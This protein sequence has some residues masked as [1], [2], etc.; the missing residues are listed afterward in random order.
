MTDATQPPTPS[1]RPNRAERRAAARGRGTTER[2]AVPVPRTVGRTD[3]KPHGG[4][5]TAPRRTG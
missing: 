5:P 3:T 1:P 4:A 2:T